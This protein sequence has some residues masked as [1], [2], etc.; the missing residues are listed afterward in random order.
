V[1]RPTVIIEPSHD[2]PLVWFDIAIRGGAAADPVG[3]E[4]LHRHAALLARRG[5]GRRDRAELDETLDSLGAALDISV[6]RDAVTLSGLALSRHLDAVIELAAD[7]LAAPRFAEDEHARLLRET[8]QVLD[9][10][11]DDDSALATRWFDWQCCP[12]H[13]YGRT[14]LGTEASIAGIERATALALWRSEVVADNLVIGLAGDIDEASAARI[15]QRLIERLPAAAGSAPVHEVP[16]QAAPGRRLILVDKPDRSQAQL[17]IG[18]LS[19]RYGVGDTPALAIAEAV[20]G[21]MFS[22]RLMQEIRVKRGWSYGA[23]CALRRSRL[24]HWFEIWMAA[25]IDVAGPAVQLTLD[26][27]AD[28]A[29]RGPTDDEV[30]FARS[31]LVGAMPFHV[32]TARQRMQLAVRDAV[33]ELPAGFTAK[34][35][36]ALGALSANDVRAACARYLLPDSVVTVAVTTADQAREA[37]EAAG[38]GALTVVG[39]D[40]Y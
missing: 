5:A 22:S 12:G 16:A 10:I 32:A 8:P 27:F 15:V 33:F 9:E 39:H 35:P 37:L 29:A 38:A 2:T 36:E 28:Y 34:L 14:S 21:G 24:P 7:V 6:S 30:D 25:G 1:P 19:A 20:L 40:E 26:L 31:Y 18:H 23:G 11:R 17:R 4:G 13:A 3:L